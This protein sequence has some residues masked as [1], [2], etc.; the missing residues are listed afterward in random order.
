M[1]IKIRSQ[2]IIASNG[3]LTER[4]EYIKELRST[5]KFNSFESSSNEEKPGKRVLVLGSG[6]VCP[7]LIEYLLRDESMM[8]VLGKT[9]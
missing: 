8:I 1:L 4:F 5:I 7:P 2:S 3:S 9:R 6:H